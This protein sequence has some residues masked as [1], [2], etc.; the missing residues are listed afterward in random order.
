MSEVKVIGHRGNLDY[1]RENSKKAI[2][3]CSRN[4][5]IDGTEF[6]IRPTSDNKIVVIHN[7]TLNGITNRKGKISE[8]KLE[9]LKKLQFKTSKID[10]MVQ[11][12][13]NISN[14]TFK[15]QYNL[16]SKTT[17]EIPTLEE[18][19]ENFRCDKHMLIEL[20]GN[21]NEYSKKQQE[22]FENNLIELLLKYDY[23]NRNIALES[24]NFESLYRIKEKLND[25]DIIA[26][27]NKRGNL[28]CL[29]MPFDGVSFEHDLLNENLIEEIIKKEL[30][31]YSWDDK[32][33]L[34][35]YKH[36]KSLIEKYNENIKS[37]ELDLT[38]INDFPE[39]AKKYIKL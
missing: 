14:K 18:I 33:S 29:N 28:D 21:I 32:N 2:L 20:K 31:L 34:K 16:L 37:K 24:Y 30:K 35:H 4:I 11:N 22:Y 6:D 39:Q 27:V 9:E 7:N 3:S 8:Y 23:K 19:I 26:L 5:L 13:N 36:I 25:I 38:I 15:N 12:I 1:A 10:I 17:S